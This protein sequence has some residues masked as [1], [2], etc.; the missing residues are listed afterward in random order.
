MDALLQKA[1]PGPVPWFT[2]TVVAV[3]ECQ[4]LPV[5]CSALDLESRMQLLRA[6][7]CS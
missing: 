2:K 1:M 4:I 6:A 7:P 5:L 3:I